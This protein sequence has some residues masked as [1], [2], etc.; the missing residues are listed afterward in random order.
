MSGSNRL[1]GVAISCFVIALVMQV[2]TAWASAEGA[3]GGFSWAQVVVLVGIGAAWGDMRR[4]VA[5]LRR[6]FDELRKGV[7]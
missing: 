2:G 6:D 5:D 4:Q 1:W 3:V 7:K